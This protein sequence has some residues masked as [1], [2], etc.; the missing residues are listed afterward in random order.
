MDLKTQRRQALIARL[1]MTSA[2]EGRLMTLDEI[3][4][5]ERAVA[6]IS[7]HVSRKPNSESLG[8]ETKGHHL[9]MT[10]FG[11]GCEPA[12]TYQETY[13]R[14]TGKRALAGGYI[15]VISDRCIR[16][17]SQRRKQLWHEAIIG[18]PTD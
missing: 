9:F 11:I 3:A 12:S 15:T 7:L 6:S 16:Y 14:V 18:I 13:L 1:D 5:F 17:L 8:A 10:Y 2:F 4:R